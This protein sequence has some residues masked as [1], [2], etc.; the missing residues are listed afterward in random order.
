M[1]LL[2]IIFTCTVVQGFTEKATGV[3]ITT[4]K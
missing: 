1:K 4:H 2:G 3:I